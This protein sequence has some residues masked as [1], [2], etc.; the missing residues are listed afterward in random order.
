MHSNGIK[1]WI[2]EEKSEKLLGY[3]ETSSSGL[4]MRELIMPVTTLSAKS[5]W[6]VPL[7]TETD[8]F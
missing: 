2:L 6:G 8:L 1:L 7:G 4:T 5:G 3:G